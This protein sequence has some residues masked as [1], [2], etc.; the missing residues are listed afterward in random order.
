MTHPTQ[1]LEAPVTDEAITRGA[2]WLCENVLRIKWDGHYSGR[3]SDRGFDPW[4]G[5][6]TGLNALQ[7]DYRDAVRAIIQEVRIEAMTKPTEREVMPVEAGQSTA[8]A[9]SK[10]LDSQPPPSGPSPAA[11]AAR[12]P[13]AELPHIRH[14][15][16]VIGGKVV[17]DPSPPAL[18]GLPDLLAD[19]KCIAE[20]MIGPPYNHDED[21]E[22]V[23]RAIATIA[24]IP[25]RE[26]RIA[27]QAA[28]IERLKGEQLTKIQQQNAQIEADYDETE[29]LRRD[30]AALR[31]VLR[32]FVSFRQKGSVE[33]FL[34]T[35][36]KARA[37]LAETTH[38]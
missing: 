5:G 11:W 30:N 25:D 3:S 7:D 14:D 34:D 20:G 12:Y 23:N 9:V 24:A 16:R 33:E 31:E 13:I 10:R 1:R 21:A 6:I 22:I 4:I 32:A 19:L 35:T 8:P 36:D 38:A 17:V 29:R 37:L 26:R 2:K 28:E 15:D 27:E 18:E